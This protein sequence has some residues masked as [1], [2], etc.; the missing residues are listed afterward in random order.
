MTHIPFTNTGHGHVWPRPDG[1]RMRCSG[2]YMCKECQADAAQFGHKVLW[3]K[4]QTYEKKIRDL[5]SQ[6]N[7][8]EWEVERYDGMHGLS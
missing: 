5:E 3:E 7:K 4:P 8:L 1:T 2:T 6:L